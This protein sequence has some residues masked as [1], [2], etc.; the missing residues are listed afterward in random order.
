MDSSDRVV[1]F[2]LVGP[3]RRHGLLHDWGSEMARPTLGH[4]CVP[5][6]FVSAG[7]SVRSPAVLLIPK[8]NTDIPRFIG[9]VGGPKTGRYVEFPLKR[10]EQN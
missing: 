10:I 9:M 7:I 3:R 6:I 1:V 8:S 4:R 5:A 2:I